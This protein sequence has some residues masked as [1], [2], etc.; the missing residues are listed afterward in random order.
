MFDYPEVHQGFRRDTALTSQG[1]Y[2]TVDLW[3]NGDTP[4]ASGADSERN[5][6]GIT[7]VVSEA[8][9]ISKIPDFFNAFCLGDGSDPL[10][11]SVAH[12]ASAPLSP[13]PLR[14]R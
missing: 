11:L 2:L 10:F 9:C 7:P 12:I 3:I 5:L 1:L 8:V 4:P 13:Y 6:S 14:S